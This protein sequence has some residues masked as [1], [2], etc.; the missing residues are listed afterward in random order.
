MKKKLAI[1]FHS[2][3]NKIMI[4]VAIIAIIALF[5]VY[6]FHEELSWVCLIPIVGFIAC[7]VGAYRI[8]R[9]RIEL[10]EERSVLKLYDFH[11]R[12]IPIKEVEGIAREIVPSVR[13]AF[14]YE[15]KI[16]CRGNVIHE[17]HMEAPEKG[18][19]HWNEVN[20]N[21]K[22]LKKRIKE[23]KRELKGRREDDKG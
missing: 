15:F 1:H 17:I 13:G 10:D 7:S 11:T 12:I 21:F 5:F 19:R 4:L 16:I 14:F 9:G 22:R 23:V 6:F 3:W 2:I 8:L 20:N 18:S